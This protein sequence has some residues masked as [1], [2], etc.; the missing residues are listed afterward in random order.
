MNNRPINIF[1]SDFTVESLSDY[2]MGSI[3]STIYLC[4]IFESAYL[5]GRAITL[6]YFVVTIKVLF[7]DREYQV[8]A[9]TCLFGDGDGCD[10]GCA[11]C[12]KRIGSF[13]ALEE[14]IELIQLHACGV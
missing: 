8:T 1:E 12:G 6:D 4:L 9:F 14:V 7:D 3:L 10:V 5:V 2:C 13:I 11:T